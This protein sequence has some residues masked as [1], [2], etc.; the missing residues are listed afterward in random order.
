MSSPSATKRSK[1]DLAARPL[2]PTHVRI[3]GATRTGRKDRLVIVDASL[4]RRRVGGTVPS[5][6]C[7]RR[8]DS[9]V[10]GFP[11][12]LRGGARGGPLARPGGCLPPGPGD[13]PDVATPP[14]LLP[15]A[16]ASFPLLLTPPDH[17]ALST[18]TH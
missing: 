6:R 3:A 8:V 11:G 1:S 10:R 7:A 13:T 9:A 15:D 16:H 4:P 5:A 17:S 2:Q 12:R 14:G 18:H